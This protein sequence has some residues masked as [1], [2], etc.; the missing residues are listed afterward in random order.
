MKYLLLPALAF[1]ARSYDALSFRVWPR[2]HCSHSGKEQILIDFRLSE[3]NCSCQCPLKPR[4][5]K[6]RST[7]LIQ[8]PSISADSQSQGSIKGTPFS[9]TR[10]PDPGC[11]VRVL[12]YPAPNELL[13][14]IDEWE[15]ECFGNSLTLNILITLVK[16][17]PK[18]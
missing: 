1:P 10:H 3:P 11:R 13:F 16:E 14:E 9:H 7:L 6:A 17:F 8:R 18:P 12:S 5:R 2:T 15:I 4:G